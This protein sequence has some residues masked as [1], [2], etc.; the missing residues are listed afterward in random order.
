MKNLVK[1]DKFVLESNTENVKPA[2]FVAD[3]EKTL[4]NTL[5]S[6]AYIDVATATVLNSPYIRIRFAASATN[7]NGVQGQKPQI[8]SLNLDIKTLELT[9]QVYGGNGG[10][11]IFRKPDK[12]N[13][14]EKFLAMQSIKVPFRKPKPEIEKILAAIEKFAKNWLDLLKENKDALMYQNVVDYDEFFKS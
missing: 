11:H 5:P 10:Q 9:P 13:P 6:K 8:V 1:F 2:E 14:A 7:I 12:N 3:I 4:K